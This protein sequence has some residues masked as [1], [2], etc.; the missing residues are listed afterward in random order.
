MY[1]KSIK[2]VYMF[3]ILRIHNNYFNVM[4]GCNLFYAKVR[5]FC[6]PAKSFNPFL[7]L[8]H[9]NVSYVIVC[10]IVVVVIIN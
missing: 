8:G 5:T 9:N 10:I 7:L 3:S 2:D 6:V 4:P 1:I